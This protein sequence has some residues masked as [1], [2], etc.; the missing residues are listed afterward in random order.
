[1]NDYNNLDV[2]AHLVE[3]VCSET[4]ELEPR[5]IAE[6]YGIKIKE[7]SLPAATMGIFTFIGMFSYIVLDIDDFADMQQYVIAVALFYYLKQTPRVMLRE[8]PSDGDFTAAHFAYD[9][10][11]RMEKETDKEG[12]MPREIMRRAKELLN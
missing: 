4:R 8:G 6:A 11:C 5:K 12:L 7:E 9:L 1:M 10:I 3:Q 2:T